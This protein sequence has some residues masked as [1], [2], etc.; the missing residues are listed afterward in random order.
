MKIQ[1]KKKLVGEKKRK[2]KNE[3]PDEEVEQLV[4]GLVVRT[5]TGR[6]VKPNAKYQ[7]TNSMPRFKRSS[8]FDI[9]SRLKY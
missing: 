6:L 1:I 8:Q 4:N 3:A 2:K 7:F 9:A 5:R